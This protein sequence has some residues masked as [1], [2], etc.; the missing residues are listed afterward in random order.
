ML[1]LIV[2]VPHNTDAQLLMTVAIAYADYKNKNR[3]QFGAEYDSSIAD[4]SGYDLSQFEP[5]FVTVKDGIAEYTF[6]ADVL[7]QYLVDRLVELQNITPLICTLKTVVSMTRQSGC[8]NIQ[9]GWA[10]LTTPLYIACFG[11]ERRHDSGGIYDGGGNI[12]GNA[13]PSRARRKAI[14]TRRD[15]KR[16]QTL[17]AREN[18]P[19]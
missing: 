5:D 12:G 11:K 14:F 18:S 9:I 15:N 10:T 7:D 13:T 4:Y 19:R 17:V 8:T 1:K 6:N 3:Y 16:T 2:K